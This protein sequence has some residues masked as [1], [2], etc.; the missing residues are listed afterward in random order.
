[1]KP[2][3]LVMVGGRSNGKRI[4]MMQQIKAA[5]NAGH[6]VYYN[7][8]TIKSEDKLTDAQL[9]A[10]MALD[11]LGKRKDLFGLATRNFALRGLPVAADTGIRPNDEGIA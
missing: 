6:I 1:M 3:E 7:G 2:G 9:A 5:L 4:V 11:H 10:V 8:H